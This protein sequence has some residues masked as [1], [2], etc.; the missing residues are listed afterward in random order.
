MS[1]DADMNMGLIDEKQ[2]RKRRKHV[3]KEANFYGAMD[4]ASKFVKGDAIAGILIVLI[5]IIGGL[6]IGIAQKG[7]PWSDAVYTYTLLTVGD[8]IVTQIPAL[9]I[10]TATGIIVTRAATDAQFGMEITR[11]ITR[12]PKTLVMLSVALLGLLFLP[13]IPAF[14]VII[15]LAIALSLAYVAFKHHNEEVDD[16]DYDYDESINTDDER[17]EKLYK[18][19]QVDP[20]TLHVGTNLLSL[21]AEDENENDS[22]IERINR[23]REQLAEEL[24]F[25]VPSTKIIIKDNLDPDRYEIHIFDSKIATGTLHRE[26]LLAISATDKSSTLEGISTTDPSYGLPALWI[27]STHK[28]SA[29]EQGFTVVDSDTVLLT[30]CSEI[31]RRHTPELL[32]RNETEKL[33]YRVKQTQPVLYEDVIPNTISLA[34]LQSILQLLLEERVSIRN[35]PLIFEALLGQAKRPKRLGL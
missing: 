3:E 10:S 21:A 19:L 5:D 27:D 2:A 34:E 12:Y 29:I 35:M 14:P 4:G 22:I 16:D 33:I 24:G 11:Q 31:I 8:G 17:D 32:T 1:I 18:T 26:K 7:M 9:I 15:V 28:D 30:H 25:V 20:L 13:S 6:A 23:L